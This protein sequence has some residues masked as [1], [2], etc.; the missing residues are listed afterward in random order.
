MYFVVYSLILFYSIETKN[1]VD[2]RGDD[3]Y[4]WSR[5]KVH[6]YI[7][8]DCEFQCISITVIIVSSELQHKSFV[9]A[10]IIDDRVHMCIV[11]VQPE[12]F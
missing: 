1:D 12:L 7:L 11:P 5:F 8:A 6:R 9:S 10:G 3:S 2:N 4:S